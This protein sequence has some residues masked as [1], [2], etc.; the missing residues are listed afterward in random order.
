MYTEYSNKLH[1]RYSKLNEM[2]KFHYTVNI[3]SKLS[4]FSLDFIS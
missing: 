2:Q 3:H 1:V 4:P